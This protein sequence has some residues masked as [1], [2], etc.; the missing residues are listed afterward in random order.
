VFFADPFTSDADAVNALEDFD[1]ILCTRERTP[2]PHALVAKLPKLAMFGLTGH[3][4]GKIDLAA[5]RSAASSSRSPKADPGV[6]STAELGLA[7]MLAAARGL[8]QGRRRP[9]AGPLPARH[10]DRASCSAGKTLG[11]V[12]LGRIGAQMARYGQALGMSVPRVE[13]EPDGRARGRGRRR[14]VDKAA[15]LAES[16]SSA[17]ISSCPTA[18]AA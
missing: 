18:R 15:L 16:E 12:G 6:E 4:A 1:A 10:A 11:L 3:R 7:L 5:C 9:R 8:P 13:P 2:F 14:R 17:C